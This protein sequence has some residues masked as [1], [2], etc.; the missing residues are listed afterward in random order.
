MQKNLWNISYPNIE[1]TVK[2]SILNLSLYETIF[3]CS[4][5]EKKI[6]KN[7][8]P[9]FKYNT[10]ITVWFECK[11]I[12]L[13][14]PNKIHGI[15][16]FLFHFC[17]KLCCCNVIHKPKNIKKKFEVCKFIYATEIKCIIKFNQIKIQ[18]VLTQHKN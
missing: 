4:A 16:R 11:I 18:K 10:I 14:D 15:Y 12:A 1:Q 8:Y 13:F 6:I 7:F 17:D 3:Y 5:V 9:R 2:F